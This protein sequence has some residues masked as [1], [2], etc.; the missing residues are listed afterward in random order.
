MRSQSQT[1]GC[2]NKSSSFVERTVVWTVW[3]FWEDVEISVSVHWTSVC[4]LLFHLSF[5]HFTFC[6]CVTCEQ[7]PGK[8]CLRLFWLSYGRRAS[9][10]L[11]FNL[12]FLVFFGKNSAWFHYWC[13][14]P[15]LFTLWQEYLLQAEKLKQKKNFSFAW[16][17]KKAN[18]RWVT[19]GQT[20]RRSV[21]HMAA[22]DSAPPLH[23]LIN[24]P[25]QK[26]SLHQRN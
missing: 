23:L 25:K 24:Q 20:A 6:L 10:T 8:Q 12:L 26:K 17:K 11:S 5:Y 4:S 3:R 14:F 18:I 2:V 21:L 13:Y 22:E 9:F 16:L 19:W 7:W 1:A 15:T